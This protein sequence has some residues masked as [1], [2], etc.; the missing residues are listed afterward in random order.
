LEKKKKDEK[1]RNRFVAWRTNGGG[2]SHM[3]TVAVRGY[4]DCL[5]SF[6]VVSPSLRR[7]LVTWLAPPPLLRVFSHSLATQPLHFFPPRIRSRHP[8]PS[9]ITTIFPCAG[10][11]HPSSYGHLG[12]RGGRGT[13]VS[14]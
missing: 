10:S 6:W 12:A 3:P 11:D 14:A 7:V 9:P 13:F 1:R 4:H 5:F 8:S 2:T